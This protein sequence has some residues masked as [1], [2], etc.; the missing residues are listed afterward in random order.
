MS[1]RPMYTK[2]VK[3]VSYRTMGDTLMGSVHWWGASP[4]HSPSCE[5]FDSLPLFLL[6]P[7]FSLFP[8]T[9]I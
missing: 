8:I 5:Q 3:G 2:E 7:P 9:S 4:N 6:L 1:A